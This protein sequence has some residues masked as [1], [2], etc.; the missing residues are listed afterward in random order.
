MQGQKTTHR[1]IPVA[2]LRTYTVQG[3]NLIAASGHSRSGEQLNVDGIAPRVPRTG[4]W[5]DSD[6]CRQKQVSGAQALSARVLV[7]GADPVAD[8]PS[9]GLRTPHQVKMAPFCIATSRPDT[10]TFRMS[11]SNDETEPDPEWGSVYWTKLRG[12]E[13]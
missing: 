7:R 2:F 8:Q 11:I 5:A 9:P 12:E 3:K 6:V 4:L 10:T 1:H 13:M